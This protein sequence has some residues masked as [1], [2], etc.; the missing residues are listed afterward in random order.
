MW[1]RK[2][3]RKHGTTQGSPRRETHSEGIRYKPQGGEIRMCPGVGRMGPIKFPLPGNA[4]W[5][6]VLPG[7][8]LTAG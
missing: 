8:F 2:A 6:R 1:R 5:T 3:Q 4:R 7:F